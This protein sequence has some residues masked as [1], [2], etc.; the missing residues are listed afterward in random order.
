MQGQN[1]PSEQPSHLAPALTAV[2]LGAVMLAG[3]WWYARSLEDRS[4]TALA[5]DQAIIE[6]ESKLIPL[7]NQGSALQQSAVETDGLL[8]VYG[9]SELIV[10]AAY[11]RPFHATNLFRDQPT[12]FT[13]FPVGGAGTT[14]LINL[15]KLAA[16]GS[17]LKGRKLVVSVSPAW[18]FKALSAWAD[19]YAGNFSPLHAGE[20]AFNTG[21]SLELRQDAARRMLRYGETVA[22]RP[23]LKFA[24]ESLADGSP[25]KLA[26]YLS[27][28]P[29]GIVHNA[30][31]RLRDHWNAVSY[32]WTHPP[33]TPSPISPRGGRQLDWP[34]LHRQAD[35][36]YRAHSSNNEL[37]MDNE[38]WER[39]LRQ[40]MAR[41]R[42]TWSDQTFLRTLERSQEWVDL[43]LLLR[44]LTELGAQPLVVSVPIHGGW[45]DQLGI[46]YT[47]RRAY[48][49]KLREV[50]GRYHTAVVDFADH[51]ADR[52][53]CH[54]S[55]GHLAPGGLVHY[56]QVF[57][58]FFH[59]STPRPCELPGPG[60]NHLT[61]AS[62]SA[63]S[64][65]QR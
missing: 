11:T 10:L 34:L 4:I 44:E 43:A 55:T 13:V 50:A 24:L 7:K 46:T 26:C 49:A 58:G 12:G 16:L 57:D 8:P 18:F 48:Y 23:L 51:D 29:L 63:A 47:A 3:F 30:I 41:K 36:L 53:F 33:R 15:Q 61:N 35:A 62:A 60:L 22:D 45:Y 21:L 59:D 17:T 65:R 37:G 9:S 32:F 25:S 28:L 1:Q 6:R 2:I 54:D 42:N 31:L 20:L 27:V 64:L 52:S 56:G 38:Q 5:A 14:C 40:A 19:Q 39:Q